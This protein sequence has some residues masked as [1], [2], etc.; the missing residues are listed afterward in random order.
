[1][2]AGEPP[3]IRPLTVLLVAIT[4]DNSE[5][6]NIK[7]KKIEYFVLVGTVPSVRDAMTIRKEMAIDIRILL[8]VYSF[9]K[10]YNSNCK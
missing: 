5:D 9:L 8:L 10:V 3:M 2:A 7:F 4:N 6:K 1:M